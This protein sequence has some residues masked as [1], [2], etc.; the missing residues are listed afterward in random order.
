MEIFSLINLIVSL[1]AVGWFASRGRQ[2]V[3][4]TGQAALPAPDAHRL[5]KVWDNRSCEYRRTGWW[6]ECTCGMKKPTTD[7][8][9]GTYG[10]EAGAIRSFK[11]HADLHKGL[12][13]EQANPFEKK[14][15]DEVEAFKEFR[16]KCFCKETNDD[17]IVLNHRH[18]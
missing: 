8:T 15:N 5:V 12:Q 9:V 10:T 2:A 18:L 16:D 11:N 7:M 1:G 4:R 17:L 14:Y 3:S 13:I 6:F